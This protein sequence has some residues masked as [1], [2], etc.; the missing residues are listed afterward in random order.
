[1]R[2]AIT[3]KVLLVSSDKSLRGQLRAWLVHEGI[4]GNILFAVATGQACQTVVSQI[5]PRVMVIDDAIPDTAGPTLLRTLRQQ[6]PD[7][8]VVYLA[9][10]HTA[11]LER[12]VRQLGVLYY[13]EKPPDEGALRKVLGTVLHQPLPQGS[14]VCVNM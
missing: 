5:R 12:E 9:T 6:L 3:G 10:H 8:L 14:A 2:R 11:E 1:M 13:T 4:R 7:S